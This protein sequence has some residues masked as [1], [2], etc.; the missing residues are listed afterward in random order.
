MVL[1][2]T[3]SPLVAL[4]LLCLPAT[5]KDYFLT[6]GGGYSPSGNQV[7][8]EKNVL[9]FQHLL[10]ESYPNGAAHQVLF[11]D[12]RD[13]GRDLQ[14]YDEA[15]LPALNR[16]LARLFKQTKELGFEYRN[17]NIP[18]VHAASTKETI[19]RWFSEHGK[20]LGDGDRLLIYVTAHGGSASDKKNAPYN[21]K[22]Y[23]W[24]QQHIEVKDFV[25]LLDTLDP[26]VQVITVMVQCFAGGYANIAF[27]E[28]DESR[29]ASAANRCGF[30][31]TVHDR[32]AAGCTPDID[33]ANYHEYSTYF[34]Q[35]I[36]GKS[37]LEEPIEQPDYDGDGR[38]SFEDAHA[39]ALIHSN[40]IDVSIKTSDRFLRA[41]SKL[42]DKDHQELLSADTPY[43]ELLAAGRP[44][45]RAVLEQLSAELELSGDRR[46]EAAREAK[47]KLEA[48]KNKAEAERK[49]AE[50]EF[51]AA[52]EAIRKALL[53]RWPEL[54]NIWNPAAQDLLA[55]ERAEMQQFIESHGEFSKFSVKHDEMEQFSEQKR[56]V[57]RRMAKC[58]RVIRTLET[59]ALAANLKQVADKQTVVQYERLREAEAGGLGE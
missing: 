6:I 37:R 21:T 10:A 41:K 15:R 14:F 52:R 12:G 57:E 2:A 29:P 44:A 56:D 8:L 19:E 5:A 54:A 45:E 42:S 59:V 48:D 28:A 47:K 58:D 13:P 23:L 24:N 51:N 11:A 1:R 35:A 9:M 26:E 30:F 22:L 7:S 43:A 20:Q 50:G 16:Y 49:K 25:K 17:S 27:E 46:A 33:E 39:Y 32:V 40:T 18:D 36:R 55:G 38:V 53:N 34:W 3:L 31:A 4:S